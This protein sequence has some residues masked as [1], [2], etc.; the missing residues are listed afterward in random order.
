VFRQVTA[1]TEAAYNAA[2]VDPLTHG[3][4]RL[5]AAELSVQLREQGEHR[6]LEQLDRTPA[7]ATLLRGAAHLPE[8]MRRLAAVLDDVGPAVAAP[9]V[10]SVTGLLAVGVEITERRAQTAGQSVAA[11]ALAAMT[12]DL[13]RLAAA[14]MA[15]LSS[16][17]ARLRMLTTGMHGQLRGLAGRPAAAALPAVLG[18]VREAP[19]VAAAL[20]AA[21]EATAG[22]GRCSSARWKVPGP[23]RVGQTCGGCR[24]AHPRTCTA[25]RCS[26]SCAPP[27]TR[28]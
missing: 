25:T 12:P 20:T 26:P 10:R 14:N 2:G 27:G 1:P 5:A 16:P 9:D 6:Y 18:W 8:G 17:D 21:A 3:L 15:T 13:R 4:V 22:T 23:S 24:S 19:A 7:R 11:D 28:W